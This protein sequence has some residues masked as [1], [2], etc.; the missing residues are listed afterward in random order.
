MYQNITIVGN[1]GQNPVVRNTDPD[2]PMVTMSVAVNKT[3]GSGVERTTQTTWFSVVAFGKV[4]LEAMKFGKGDTVRVNGEVSI[5]TWTNQQ[6]KEIAQ[7]Q[8]TAA[9]VGLEGQS[10]QVVGQVVAQPEVREVNSKTHEGTDVLIEFAVKGKDGKITV[11]TMWGERVRKLQQYLVAGKHVFVA[12]NDP[13]VTTYK[14][15]GETY[16]VIAVT[17]RV[18]QLL[19]VKN[20]VEQALKTDD[21]GE[22]SL[23]F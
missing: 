11:V 10:Y 20:A 23:P 21:D 3:K 18:L 12:G 15:K 5:N 14:E 19:T 4:A 13:R 22:S 1:L 8:I 9:E 17:A 2:N 16:A 7:L 6:G